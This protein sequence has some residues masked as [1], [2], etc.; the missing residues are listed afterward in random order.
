MELKQ[1][2]IF[3]LLAP[4]CTV[5]FLMAI[6]CDHSSGSG[7]GDHAQ[8]VSTPDL[9]NN[10]QANAKSRIVDAG[11]EVGTIS[12]E[13]SDSIDAGN[14]VRQEP[15]GGRRIELGTKV[16]IIISGGFSAC[17]VNFPDPV[18]EEHIREASGIATGPISVS[19]LETLTTLHFNNY[20]N[21]SKISTIEGIQYCTSIME[22][23][24]SHNNISEVDVLS[25]LINLKSL[26]LGSN[27]IVDIEAL[28]GLAQLQTLILRENLIE[29]IEILSA[30]TNIQYLDI[31]SNPIVNIEALSGL[32]SLQKLYVY[33][34]QLT[35]I[36]AL[37][38][39]NQLRE[40]G[41]QGCPISDI[42]PLSGLTNLSRL[43]LWY[44]NTLKNIDVL[45]G[46]I[47]LT[48]LELARNQIED[49]HPLVENPGIGEGDSIYL[50][51]NP[52]DALSCS[53]YIPQ[54][55]ARGAAIEHDCPKS[56][57]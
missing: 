5:F 6:G 25:R 48:F 13:C 52:L 12:T 2:S 55:E 7:C 34:T 56:S 53:T 22:L 3:I 24:L 19:A 38:G 8:M 37:S 41:L 31:G 49:I 9:V 20:E 39:L 10:D 23:D 42:S 33:S 50:R 36:E 18:L 28:S 57:L 32:N 35:E 1:S 4:L 14:V 46:L 16:D 11:L 40:L 21:Q 51:N 29:N 26:D 43:N 47:N 15:A 17:N 54:L 30:L 45:A 44:T 27:L